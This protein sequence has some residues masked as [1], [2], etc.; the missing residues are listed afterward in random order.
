MFED[1]FTAS[2]EDRQLIA[3]IALRASRVYVAM[4]ME[5]A[6]IAICMDLEAVHCNG[7]PLMLREMRD[8]IYE[9]DYNNVMHDINGIGD[10]LDRKTG[11]LTGL[12]LPRFAVP[13]G[14]EA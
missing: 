14:G 9:A 8:A 1:M 7:C 6:E 2:K 3:E 5:R 13:E 4:G 10:H 12:F 11:E